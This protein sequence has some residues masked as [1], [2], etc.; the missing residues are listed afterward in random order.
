VALSKGFYPLLIDIDAARTIETIELTSELPYLSISPGADHP[1][2]DAKRFAT[3]EWL[4]PRLIGTSTPIIM[5]TAWLWSMG[6][7][8]LPFVQRL[9]EAGVKLTLGRFA[10]HGIQQWPLSL[11]HGLRPVIGELAADTTVHY[12]SHHF[13][14]SQCRAFLLDILDAGA[15]W[16]PIL[17]RDEWHHFGESGRKAAAQWFPWLDRHGD[18]AKTQLAAETFLTIWPHKGRDVD[19][20]RWLARAVPHLVRPSKKA[21][22]KM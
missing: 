14:S 12:L 13:L 17:W 7:S 10:D 1:V 11:L 9:R 3:M 16:M 18:P 20:K 8:R 19:I 4:L 15:S 21:R 6:R 22:L 5:P 2:F